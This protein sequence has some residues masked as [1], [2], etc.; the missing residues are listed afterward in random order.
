R[1]VGLDRGPAS[2]ADDFNADLACPEQLR[3]VL[4]TVQPDYV[5][6]LAAITFVPHGDLLEM[7]QTNLFGT[8]NLLDAILAVG[9]SP[10]KVL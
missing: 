4:A 9:L 7:Y 1:V 10:R 5:I 2:G 3:A 8:L 6:H